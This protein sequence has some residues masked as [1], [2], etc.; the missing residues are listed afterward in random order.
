[1]VAGGGRKEGKEEKKKG[2]KDK[3]RGL[4]FRPLIPL[5]M[6]SDVGIRRGEKKRDEGG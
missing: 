6:L 2:R 1:V 4:F 5:S 3:E